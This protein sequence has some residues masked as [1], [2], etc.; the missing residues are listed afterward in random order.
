MLKGG[1]FPGMGW[2]RLNV[3]QA[4]RAKREQRWKNKRRERARQV[5]EL[6]F[7]PQGQEVFFTESDLT[8]PMMTA[9][10]AALKILGAKMHLRDDAVWK[11]VKEGRQILPPAILAKMETMGPTVDN[12]ASWQFLNQL[13]ALK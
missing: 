5:L 3:L 2:R 10:A 12:N 6:E 8:D 1:H 7:W 13:S 9:K 4:L 11:L